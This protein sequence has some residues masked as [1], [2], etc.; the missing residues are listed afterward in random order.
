MGICKICYGK[1]KKNAKMLINAN[2]K[3]EKNASVRKN[4]K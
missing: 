2:E 1:D 4:L 3:Y